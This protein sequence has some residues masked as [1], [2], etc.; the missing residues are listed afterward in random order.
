MRAP[1]KQGLCPVCGRLT[2]LRS[3]GMIW[4]HGQGG[5]CAGSGRGPETRTPDQI[6]RDRHAA[7][8]REKRARNPELLK[9]QWQRAKVRNRALSQLAEENRQRFEELLA[10]EYRKECEDS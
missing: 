7:K 5:V 6:R 9:R 4:T 8:M 3:D 2:M 10:E 1:R